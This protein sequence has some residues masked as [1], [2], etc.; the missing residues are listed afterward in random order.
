MNTIQSAYLKAKSAYDQAF[1]AENWELVEQLEDTYIDAEITLVNWA[2]DQATS[3]GL[4]K[5][6]EEKLLRTHWTLKP[7]NDRIINLA[8]KLTAI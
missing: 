3:T 5:P 7:Y 1:A 2:I 4:M 8:L 6:E